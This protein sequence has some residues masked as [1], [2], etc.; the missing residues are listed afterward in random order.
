VELEPPS[1]DGIIGEREAKGYLARYGIPLVSET[2][3]AV[4]NGEVV[5]PSDWPLAFPVAVKVDTIDIKSR[6]QAGLIRLDVGSPTEALSVGRSLVRRCRQRGLAIRGLLVQE[7]VRG[8]EVFVGG[9][10]DPSFG[11][12]VAVGMG[13]PLVEVLSRPVLR[14]PPLPIDEAREA[15]T[16][17]EIAGQLS[18]RQTAAV[19]EAL[20]RLSRLLWDQADWI[21]QVDVNPLFVT[22]SGVLAADALVVPVRRAGSSGLSRRQNPHH[23]LPSVDDQH[24]AGHVR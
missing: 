3:L 16:E 7:M 2:Y 8:I 9:L 6:H 21:E 5:P 1:R 17:C 18:S 13:G 11:P 24:L 4:R 22:K 19:A 10:V 14:L 15:V 23:R 20:S 12:V